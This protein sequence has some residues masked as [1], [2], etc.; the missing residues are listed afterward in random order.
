[1][2]TTFGQISAFGFR[3]SVHI[4]LFPSTNEFQSAGMTL[5]QEI[6]CTHFF[7]QNSSFK[8]QV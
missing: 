4:N 8:V 6:V 1:M 3:D 5:N 2:R 7:Y